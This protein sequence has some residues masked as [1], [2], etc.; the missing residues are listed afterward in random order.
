M[1]LPRRK[2]N[3]GETMAAE[4]AAGRLHARYVDELRQSL[5]APVAR[6]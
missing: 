2:K 6:W 1:S 4:T 5:L 3:T